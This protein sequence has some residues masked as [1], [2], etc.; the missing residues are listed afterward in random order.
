MC[1]CVCVCVLVCIGDLPAEDTHHCAV[2]SAHV[3]EVSLQGPVGVSGDPYGGC[4]SGAGGC[5]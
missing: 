3:E 5:W 2:L 4:G 1:V